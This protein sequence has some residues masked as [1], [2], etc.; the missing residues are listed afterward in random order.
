[1][2]M[3]AVG[4]DGLLLGGGDA[5]TGFGLEMGAAVVWHD[6]ERGIRDEMQG[7]TLLAQ[8]EQEFQEQG[9]ALSFS[10]QPDLSNRGPSLSLSHAV[11]ASASGGMDALLQAVVLEKL[12]APGTNGQRFEAE[13]AYGFPAYNSRLT[14]TAAVALVLSPPAGTT[15][16][17]S[18]QPAPSRDTE[19]PRG[20]SSRGAHGRQQGWGWQI[21]SLQ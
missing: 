10:W 12:A 8:G 14:V 1:M 7:R 17:G 18:W 2:E 21:L 3:A 15:A 6:P 16:C 11:G 13:V 9:L 4:M 5:E 20:C 19:R